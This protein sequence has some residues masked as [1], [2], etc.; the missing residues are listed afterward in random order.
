MPVTNHIRL[1]E[2]QFAAANAV[3]VALGTLKAAPNMVLGAK[4]L[5]VPTLQTIFKQLLMRQSDWVVQAAQL[6]KPENAIAALGAM[7]EAI[8]GKAIIEVKPIFLTTCRR[9]KPLKL[10][11]NSLLFSSKLF[12]LKLSKANQIRSSLTDSSN[13]LLKL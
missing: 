3:Q 9:F 7:I 12:F 10:T 11:A 1:P 13:F 4:L 2:Q 5:V 8:T 6:A